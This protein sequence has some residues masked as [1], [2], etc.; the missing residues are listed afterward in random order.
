MAKPN[1]TIGLYYV[2]SLGD[3]ATPTETFTATCMASSS[4]GMELSAQTAEDLIPECNPTDLDI[5]WSEKN[6]TGKSASISLEG[7]VNLDELVTY[8]A[9]Y[10]SG[11]AKNV[12]LEVYAQNADNT[13]GDLFGTWAGAF[14]LTSFSQSAPREG[15][16]T[17]SIGLESSGEVTLTPA[18]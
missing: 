14:L 8:W 2:I 6:V 16:A 18:E 12:K 15:K 7:H 13:R 4:K 5:P 1:T 3:G 10:N 9:W 11:K 17:H